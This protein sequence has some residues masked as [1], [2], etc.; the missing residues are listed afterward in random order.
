MIKFSNASVTYDGGVRAL[1]G[2]DLEIG[3]GEFIVVV[4]LSGAGKST[5]IRA[6]NGLVPLTSGSLEVYGR[7]VADLD[8]A[9]LRELRSDIGMVGAGS[10]DSLVTDRVSQLGGLL[11]AHETFQVDS[12]DVAPW[13][14]KVIESVSAARRAQDAARAERRRPIRIA[15]ARLPGIKQLHASRTASRVPHLERA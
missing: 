9:G 3:E 12:R 6:V 13:A 4:G 10:S 1:Q 5:L 14:E 15:L 7:N 2:V 11:G 8:R